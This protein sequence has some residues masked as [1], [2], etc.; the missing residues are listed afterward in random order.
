[1]EYFQS[2][3]ASDTSSTKLYVI[4]PGTSVNEALSH[5]AML[6]QQIDSVTD[7][8]LIISRS[9]LSNFLT[10]SVTCQYRLKRWNDFV[11]RHAETFD[12]VLNA[13]ARIKK[14]SSSAF[15]N[16]RKIIESDYPYRNSDH[17]KKLTSTILS[18][19]IYVN[20]ENG[21]AAAIDI[22]TVRKADTD[23]VIK[24]LNRDTEHGMCFDMTATIS[25]VA[26]GI[27]DNFSYIGWASGCIVF[28]LLC[29]SFRNW[30]LALCAFIPMAVSWIWILGI[31]SLFN[32][33][34][35]IINVV[36]ATFIFGQGADYAL[37]I[38]QGL[39]HD[40]MNNN[41]LL[42]DFR[43]TISV[44]ALIMLA[45]I[46]TLIMSS[47]PAL[48]SLAQITIIGMS[49]VVLLSFVLPPFLFKLL[50]IKSTRK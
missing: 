6:Q 36:L 10:D 47:H 24:I 46:G 43:R 31:M 33:S 39:Y 18:N 15:D 41:D 14:F 38:T 13:K 11:T 12:S 27:S 26:S 29:I 20:N 45:A 30:K 28:I 19:N 42:K 4:S 3:L 32:I 49:V 34:F 40:S 16:F 37:F 2:I 44:S 21:E 7:C 25:E 35:N 8:G 23:T 5:N 17:F 9:R 48:K 1:M 50:R 22:L